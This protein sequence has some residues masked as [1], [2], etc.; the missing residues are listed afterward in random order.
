MLDLVLIEDKPEIEHPPGMVVLKPDMSEDKRVRVIQ[1]Y[2]E[3]TLKF[4]CLKCII[5]ASFA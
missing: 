4:N 2:E 1:K 3:V 5:C